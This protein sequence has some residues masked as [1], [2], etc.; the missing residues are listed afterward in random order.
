M[1]FRYYKKILGESVLSV[2]NMN[3]LLRLSVN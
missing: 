1:I 3:R 2:K